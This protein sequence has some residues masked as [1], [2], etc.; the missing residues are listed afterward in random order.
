MPT[1]KYLI[2]GESNRID[3]LNIPMNPDSRTPLF[4][5][6]SRL[7]NVDVDDFSGCAMRKGYTVSS[8]GSGVHSFWSNPL[9]PKEAYFVEGNILK[10]RSLAGQVSI[11]RTGLTVGLR[12]FYSQINDVVAYSNGTERGVIEQGMSVVPFIPSDPF[13]LPFPAGRCLEWHNGRLYTFIAENGAYA[14]VCSDSLDTPGGIESMDDRQCIV[15]QFDGPGTMIQHVEQPG[16]FGLFVSAGSST[17][18]FPGSDPVASEDMAQYQVDQFPA[19]LGS[20]TPVPVKLVGNG[21][22][23]F[24]AFWVAG[25]R[26]CYGAPSGEVVAL[27][28]LAV[29]YATEG[30]GIIRQENGTAHYLFTLSGIQ[31]TGNIF[32]PRT[33]DVDS[34]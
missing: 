4:S 30:T 21:G 34:N 5:D 29:P 8:A 31:G 20:N 13:K 16:G 10:M 24:G 15:A 14:L 23:G 19:V 9:A 25:D 28:K 7:I 22:A 18:Y 32:V 1:A 27:D 17:F 6:W 3:P 12:M 26:V 2:Q 33:I 11:V